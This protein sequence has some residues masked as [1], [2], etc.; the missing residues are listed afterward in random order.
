MAKTQPCGARVRPHLDLYS[1]AGGWLTFGARRRSTRSCERP[2][3]TAKRP[4]GRSRRHRTDRCGVADGQTYGISQAVIYAL[5]VGAPTP[6]GRPAGRGCVRGLGRGVQRHR[7]ASAPGRRSPMTLHPPYV[8]RTKTRRRRLPGDLEG[9]L[10]LRRVWRTCSSDPG[11]E[12]DV[13]SLRPVC[14]LRRGPSLS[15]PRSRV[16]APRDLRSRDARR[17]CSAY[18]H[19]S[20]GQRRPR[21]IPGGPSR[22]GSAGPADHSRPC[23]PHD[24]ERPSSGSCAI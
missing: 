3:L 23:S 1:R 2:P 15:L 4:L 5:A 24:C 22:I 9:A 7:F 10:A 20:M 21:G 12:S 18:S 14:S 8:P 16:R 17:G 6:C 13:R 19:H 11:K